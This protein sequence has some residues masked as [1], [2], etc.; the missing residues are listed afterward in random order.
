MLN[1]LRRG[2]RL[3]LSTISG[4]RRSLGALVMATTQGRTVWLPKDSLICFGLTIPLWTIAGLGWGLAMA[5]FTSGSLIYWIFPGLLWGGSM[6]FFFSIVMAITYR[7]ISTTLP[8][9]DATALPQRLDKAAK[10]LRYI[11]EQQSSTSFVCKPKPI[12]ARLFE[13]S[14]LHVS[15]GDDS[16]DLVGP[17]IIV[18]KVRKAL[19]A[20]SPL[21][22]DQ[23]VPERY[24]KQ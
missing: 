24:E 16:V 3:N 17:A 15:M 6:W 4:K 7:E 8:L 11:V 10:R 18:K 14:R 22:A 9:Q 21:R 12:I 5:L 23:A 13:F 20:N 19:L 1:P 2:D